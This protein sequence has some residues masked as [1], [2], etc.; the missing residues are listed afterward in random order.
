M[1][2]REVLAAGGASALWATGCAKK[3]PAS[4]PNI[5]F[6]IADDQSYAHTGANQSQ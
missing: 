6:V 2:R 1:T 3:Q 4:R 5:L